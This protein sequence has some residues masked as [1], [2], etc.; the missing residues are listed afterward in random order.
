MTDKQLRRAGLDYHEF[1][2]IMNYPNLESCFKALDGKR[3]F[4]LSTKG[5]TRYSDINFI[6]GDIL[7]FGPET[8]GLPQLT[9]DAL[10]KQNVLR[11]PMR[12]DNRSLNLSNAAAIVVY[13]GLRQHNFPNEN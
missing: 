1:T 3:V 5:T 10:P 13:E 7:L 9:L 4:A 6:S 8:R 11:I 2:N 12:A